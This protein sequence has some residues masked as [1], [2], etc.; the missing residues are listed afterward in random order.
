MQFFLFKFKWISKLEHKG[1]HVIKNENAFYEAISNLKKI[2]TIF[3]KTYLNFTYG[4]TI[5]LNKVSH[6]KYF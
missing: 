3:L 4:F 1:T 2:M 5:T 6:G